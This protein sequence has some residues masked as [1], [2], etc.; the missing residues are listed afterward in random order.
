[1][2]LFGVFAKIIN[3]ALEFVIRHLVTPTSLPVLT[4]ANLK[5]VL[6]DRQYCDTCVHQLAN[7]IADIENYRGV[8]RLYL[9]RS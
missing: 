2:R 8:T 9:T 1:M 6:P 5:R 7:I 3:K 4:I